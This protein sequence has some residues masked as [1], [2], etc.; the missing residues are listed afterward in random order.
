MSKF[1][2]KVQIQVK[3]GVGLTAHIPWCSS[4]L[5]HGELLECMT[6][7]SSLKCCSAGCELGMMIERDLIEEVETSKGDEKC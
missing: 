5:D 6:R 3:D 2:F 1:S 7:V 4:V